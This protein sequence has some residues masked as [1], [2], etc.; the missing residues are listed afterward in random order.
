VRWAAAAAVGSLALFAAVSVGQMAPG[1]ALWAHPGAALGASEDSL[2][3]AES[4]RRT[5][6]ANEAESTQTARNMRDAKEMADAVLA[7]AEAEAERLAKLAAQKRKDFEIAKAET[8]EDS[9]EATS[10]I[11]ALEDDAMAKDAE[12]TSR[13]TA[14]EATRAAYA[15]STAAIVT[16][17]E[18]LKKATAAK[19][20]RLCRARQGPRHRDDC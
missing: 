20:R 9:E 15:N 7:E 2:A 18:E 3:A 4:H 11:Q 6:A 14:Y 13:T 5:A 10:G 19:E 8:V 1:A 12:L 17:G 16:L